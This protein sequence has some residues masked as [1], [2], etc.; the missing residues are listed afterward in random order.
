MGVGIRTIRA[1]LPGEL[2]KRPDDYIEMTPGVCTVVNDLEDTQEALQDLARLVYKVTK[3]ELSSHP[4]CTCGTLEELSII[5]PV[6]TERVCANCN[7]AVKQTY[8][9]DLTPL[10]FVR[11]P[12]GVAPLLDIKT[13]IQL[14]EMFTITNKG[15][16]STKSQFC[17]VSW[18]IN[19]SA[20]VTDEDIEEELIELGLKRGGYNYFVENLAYITTLLCGYKRFQG[21]VPCKKKSFTKLLDQEGNNILNDHLFMLNRDL[22]VLEEGLGNISYMNLELTDIFTVIRMF[23]GVDREEH[24]HYDNVSWKENMVGRA[25]LRLAAFYKIYFKETVSGKKGLIK[26]HV[27]GCRTN[28]GMRVVITSIA[29]DLAYNKVVLPW[30]PT[31]IMLKIYLV[32]DLIHQGYELESVNGYIESHTHKYCPILHE[33]LTRLLAQ[34]DDGMLDIIMQRFPTLSKANFA[35]RAA[36]VNP[37]PTVLAARIP[38]TSVSSSNADFDGDQMHINATATYGEKAMRNIRDKLDISRSY[39][40]VLS[41]KAKIN[42]YLKLTGTVVATVN[43]W[44][45]QDVRRNTAKHKAVLGKYG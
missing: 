10:I 33:S 43:A 6:S 41:G 12:R 35:H 19:T 44:R 37:D 21:R 34:C 32:S 11:R 23:V 42:H 28:A 40:D 16:H 25:L 20:R 2:P 3:T 22:I 45:K 31:L 15:R 7:T 14:T 36:E 24:V 9:K 29:R 39:V 8:D 1:A 26:K 27:L 13:I 5:G 18:I 17:V 30:G 4:T 38:L